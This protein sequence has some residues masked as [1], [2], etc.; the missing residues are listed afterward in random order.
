MNRILEQILKI[1]LEQVLSKLPFGTRVPAAMI[2]EL[3]VV[4][5][6]MVD[7]ELSNQK[8]LELMGKVDDLMRKYNLLRSV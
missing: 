5:A 4:A 7:G 8:Q 6:D 1:M 3:S 2:E